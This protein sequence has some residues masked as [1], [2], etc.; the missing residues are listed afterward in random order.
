MKEKNNV[1]K[2]EKLILQTEKMIDNNKAS[3]TL[4]QIK[5][6]KTSAEIDEFET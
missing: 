6:Q 5:F 1:S 3:L 2:F 4:T